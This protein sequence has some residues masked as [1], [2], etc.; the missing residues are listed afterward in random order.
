MPGRNG[1]SFLKRV[2]LHWAFYVLA[3]FAGR[4]LNT[5][6]VQIQFIVSFVAVNPKL[7]AGI[8]NFHA[9][10]RRKVCTSLAL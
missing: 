4:L 10:M 7:L 3:P 2:T 9:Q 6:V 1:F 8:V 5:G